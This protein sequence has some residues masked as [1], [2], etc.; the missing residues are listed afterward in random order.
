[1]VQ[2]PGGVSVPEIMNPDTVEPVPTPVARP[3]LRSPPWPAWRHT[4][5]VSTHVGEDR[6]SRRHLAAESSE[7]RRDGL[8]LS[9][10]HGDAV[11]NDHDVPTLPRLRLPL[12]QPAAF[13]LNHDA[14]HTENRRR[15]DRAVGV[16]DGRPRHD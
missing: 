10:E 16:R 2:Q 7:L 3:A 6:P 8:E 12:A 13:E 4:G 1:L 5:W 14:T 11:A 15:L 9:V